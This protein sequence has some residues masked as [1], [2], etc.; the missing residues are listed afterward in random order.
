MGKMWRFGFHKYRD[1]EAS[2]RLSWENHKDPSKVMERSWGRSAEKE[3]EGK[4]LQRW[5]VRRENSF[6][7]QLTSNRVRGERE[8]SWCVYSVESSVF[9]ESIQPCS[10]LEEALP[11]LWMGQESAGWKGAAREE[12]DGRPWHSKSDEPSEVLSLLELGL[13]I[14]S[15]NVCIKL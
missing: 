3:G 13:H 12:V 15:L 7:Q 1:M 11:D 8:E 14:F 5:E 9:L 4:D 6:Q 2:Q 10:Q